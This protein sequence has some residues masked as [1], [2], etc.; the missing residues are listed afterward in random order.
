MTAVEATVP[1]SE[2]RK[3]PAR[4]VSTIAQAD[5]IPY[6]AAVSE[7]KEIL[8]KIEDAERGKLRLGE[9]A[10]N[11]EPKYG[12]RTLAKYAEAIGEK[13]QRLE[14]YRSV[15]RAWNGS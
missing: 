15:W 1:H 11:L 12:D 8:A 14:T 4:K 7:G 3:Q 13:T 9:I 6:D 2:T 5:T 10:D